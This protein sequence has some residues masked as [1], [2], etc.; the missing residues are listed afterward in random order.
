MERNEIVAQLTTI[1]SEIFQVENLVLTEDMSATNVDTWTSLTFMQLLTAIEENFGFKFKMLELIKI[2]NM[3][4][5][6]R[7]IESHTN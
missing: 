7:S 1:A 5:I 4:D 3:G 2:K 6:I